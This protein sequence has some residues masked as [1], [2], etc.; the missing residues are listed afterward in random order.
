MPALQVVARKT[1]GNQPVPASTSRPFRCRK[2]VVIPVVDSHVSREGGI[3]V[4]QVSAIM[5][6]N[7][8][9]IQ[10][11]FLFGQPHEL[12]N[13]GAGFHEW[14]EG[15]NKSQGH[16]LW[17]LESKTPKTNAPNHT[18]A[19]QNNTLACTLGCT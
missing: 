17:V 14:R 15:R 4:A 3:P 18:H 16:V 12:S 11:V 13:H 6:R 8:R 9:M 7:E 19:R 2:G 1:K 10:N 5:L